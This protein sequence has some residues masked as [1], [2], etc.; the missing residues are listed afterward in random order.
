M[1]FRLQTLLGLK[2]RAEEEAEQAMAAAIAAR[3]KVELK[4]AELEAAIQRAKDRL[5]EARR[6]AMSPADVVGE[7]QARERFRQRLVDLVT[8]ATETA[9]AHRQGPLAAAIAAEQAARQAHLEARREREALEKHK[10]KEEAKERQ[11]AERRSEDAA[12]DLAIAA[13]FRN[14]QR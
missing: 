5:A 10:A 13:H 9:R 1:A 7:G 4:Q 11:I 3:A 6:A 14:K 8:A 12:S 2:L